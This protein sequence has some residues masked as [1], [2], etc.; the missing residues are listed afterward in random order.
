MMCQGVIPLVSCQAG[1]QPA[2]HLT[3]PGTHNPDCS[4]TGFAHPAPLPACCLTLT[5]CL[6]RSLRCCDQVNLAAACCPCSCSLQIPGNP[7]PDTQLPR[8]CW[9]L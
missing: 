8:S 3:S 5:F 9:V 1:S 6:C 4:W 2:A 7:W